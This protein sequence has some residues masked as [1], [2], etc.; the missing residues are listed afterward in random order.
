MPFDRQDAPV[1]MTRMINIVALLIVATIPILFAAA[2]PWVWSLYGLLMLAAF[3]VALWGMEAPTDADHDGY[4]NKMVFVFLL[5]TL[6]L[7]LPLPHRAL[8]FISPKRSAILSDTWMLNDT[9]PDLETLSYSPKAALGWWIFL[10]SLSLFYVLVRHL[11]TNRT[12]LKRLVF[13]MIAV[14]LLES[15]YGLLQALVPSMGVLWENRIV[16]YMGTARGTFINRNNFAGFI[17]MVWPLALGATLAMTGRARSFKAALGSDNLNR[18]AL[19]ALGVIV[20][21]LAL[22]FSRSRAGM[23]CALIGFLAFVIQA[24]PGMSTMVRPT[25][26]LLGGVAVLVSLYT[27]TIGVEPVIDRFLRIASDGS[28]RLEI[29][30]DSLAMIKDHP[31]GIGLRN[32]ENVFQIYNHTFTTDRPVVFA[33]NDYLQLL[34]ESGWVGFVALMGAFA[35]FLAN[36]IQRIRRLDFRGDPLRFYLAVGACSGLISMVAHGLFDFNLQIPANCLYFVLLMAILSACTS[37]RRLRPNGP[38]RPT[39]T[40]RPDRRHRHRQ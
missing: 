37:Q 7:C 38:D 31:L 1:A 25:R 34:I 40:V 17:G 14:G 28:S 20:F 4:L 24:R 19:M 18:Q 21:L 11:C 35:V 6:F 33:H 13:V 16:D 30:H 26:V 10:L 8:A 22:I 39:K 27:L 12:A 36:R 2:Q 3:A 32:Y 23:L 9:T 29:W 15:L 5:W